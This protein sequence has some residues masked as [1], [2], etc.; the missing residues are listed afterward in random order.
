MSDLFMNSLHVD[1]AQMAELLSRSSP[2]VRSVLDVVNAV[3]PVASGMAQQAVEEA[4]FTAMHIGL[5]AACVASSVAIGILLDTAEGADLSEAFETM[6]AQ[7]R[8]NLTAVAP[9]I[10]QR[11]LQGAA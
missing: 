1:D 10:E 5:M 11:A 2:R 9:L 4:P 6:N 8:A 7:L 3:Q